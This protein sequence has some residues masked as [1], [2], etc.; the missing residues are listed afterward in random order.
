LINSATDMEDSFGTGPVPNSDEGWGRVDLTPFFD[1][2]RSFR[3]V[4]QAVLLTNGQVFEQRL[5]IAS[6]EEALKVTLAYTD[7][8]DLPAAIPALVNDLDLEVVGPSGQLY[9]G[10]QFDAGESFPNPPG[11]DSIN[12]V[13]AVNLSIPQPGEY[14]VRVRG[15]S[16]VA[17]VH[18]DPTG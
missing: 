2:A 1:S 15:R 5:V 14:I 3:F 13:E 4:D 12:N 6:P 9:R 7:P 11:R 8:P 18:G 17:D 10:N 16:V